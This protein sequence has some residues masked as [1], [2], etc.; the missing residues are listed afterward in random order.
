MSNGIKRGDFQRYRNY[1][2]SKVKKIRKS[3]GFKYSSP[4]VKFSAK[5]I[6][7]ERA[8]DPR[9]LQALLFSAEKNW[10][11]ANEMKSMDNAK[12]K[13]TK[14]SR[15]KYTVIN[16]LKRSVFWALKLEQLC[17][18]TSEKKSAL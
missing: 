11:Y 10:A 3:M 14:R 5:R 1:C 2:T 6:E 17:H 13:K 4:K 15:V 12:L 9:V 7:V 8:R 16:K 18:Q